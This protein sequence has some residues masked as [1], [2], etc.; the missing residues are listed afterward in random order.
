MTLNYLQKKY[1][2]LVLHQEDKALK[3]GL[4]L[5][6]Y[7]YIIEDTYIYTR[8]KNT[9][10]IYSTNYKVYVLQIPKGAK[11]LTLVANS[12]Y[13][14]SGEYNCGV[15]YINGYTVSTAMRTTIEINIDNAYQYIGITVRKNNLTPKATFSFE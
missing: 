3:E 4:L 12:Q 8:N 10:Y 15:G 5:K 11:K 6:D 14:F 2:H 7:K 1:N 13:L 9:E